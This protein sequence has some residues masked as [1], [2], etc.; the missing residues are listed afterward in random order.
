MSMLH[1]QTENHQSNV[2]SSNPFVNQPTYES[3]ELEAIW[4]ENTGEG[5]CILCIFMK[6]GGCKDTFV[7]LGKLHERSRRQK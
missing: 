4:E 6:G 1:N 2:E 7:D 3:P 5:E